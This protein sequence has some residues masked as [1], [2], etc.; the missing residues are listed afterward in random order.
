MDKRCDNCKRSYAIGRE[1]EIR[2]VYYDKYP[3]PSECCEDWEER[4]GELINRDMAMQAVA[5]AES[6]LLAFAAVKHLPSANKTKKAG[7]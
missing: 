4:S 2:C 3:A 1:N 6:V 5:D 7:E